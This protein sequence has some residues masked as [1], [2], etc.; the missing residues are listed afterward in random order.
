MTRELQPSRGP[1]VPLEP[2]LLAS[3]SP[4]RQEI[5]RWAGIPF[6]ACP[7]D[8][9]PEA[10]AGLGPAEYCQWAA[11]AK[12]AEVARRR[13]GRLVLGA[14]TVVALGDSVLGK[15]EDEEAARAM[16]RR[17]SGRQHAVYTGLALAVGPDLACEV[18]EHERT[19][20]TF[21]DLTPDLVERYVG[22]GDP[23]DKAGAYGIQSQGG[24]LVIEVLGSYLNVVGLPLARL[25]AMLARLGWTMWETDENKAASRR[26]R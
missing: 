8:A 6:E 1:V 5:L 20:V 4:R 12:A 18:V 14:D 10:R 13:P 9:E 22:S 2:L 25:Q 7:S 26:T 3:A 17:L 23:L 24:E 16:L 19:L 11:Q 21:A 15:P